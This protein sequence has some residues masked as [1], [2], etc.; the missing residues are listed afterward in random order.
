MEPLDSIDDARLALDDARA[1]ATAELA[2]KA[3]LQFRYDDLLVKYNDLLNPPPPPP[4]PPGPSGEA[5]PTGDLPG[6]KL[7]WSENFDKPAAE[8]QIRAVYGNRMM[9]YPPRVDQAFYT[10][11][12]KRGHYETNNL[13]ADGGMLRYHVHTTADGIH[14][15]G[16]II[17]T[18]SAK[19]AAHGAYGSVSGGRF[20]VR[21]R[22]SRLPTYKVAW[23]LWPKDSDWPKNGEIDFPECS[24]DGASTI[25]GFM[26][27]Q[28]ATVGSD[29]DSVSTTAKP[30][31][32]HTCVTEWVMGQSC[33]FFLDGLLIKTVRD[34]VPATP[35]RWTLQTETSLDTTKPI[36]N[37]AAGY[38]DIDW[39]AY[40][41]PA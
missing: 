2:D 19:D 35:M 14:H 10:D 40:W 13:S 33:K 4:P 27:R 20:A 24:L 9:F 41:A 26:H 32:W 5:I 8:G 37:S 25:H 38:V 30:T 12:K 36:D 6:W 3:A 22:S 7:A 18:L 29:Q 1:A 16:A 15:V 23:L 34:R 39:L 31:D 11:T 28:G 17:P 21:W